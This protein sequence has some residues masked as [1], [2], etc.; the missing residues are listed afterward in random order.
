MFPIL[1]SV[2]DYTSKSVKSSLRYGN[3]ELVLGWSVTEEGEDGMSVEW[4][5]Q[6]PGG[7]LPY[8]RNLA[9]EIIGELEQHFE[10]SYA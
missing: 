10:N 9:E 3:S 2:P 8:L 4:E 6:E 5:A 1:P 7:C